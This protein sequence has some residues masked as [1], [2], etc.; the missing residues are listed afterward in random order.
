MSS[1]PSRR[2][3]AKP[4]NQRLAPY[5][6]VLP[7]MLIFGLF[8]V[9]P[10]INNFNISLYDS[11]NGR[12]FTFVGGAN[13]QE[14]FGSEAFC[15]AARA[16]VVFATCFVVLTTV[17]SV[18]LALMLNQ[19]IK[20]RAFFR[21]VFFLP[22]VLSPVVVGLIWG[23]IF[24]RGNGLLNTVL[25]RIGLGQPGWLVDGGLATI[26][27]I[28]VGLWMH[29]GFYILIILAGLQGID[30]TYYEAAR[31]D[32]ATN[33]QQLR[34]ITLP[35]LRP[36]TMVVVILSLIA[37]FQAFDYIWTLT[38]GGPIG[39]TTL[40]VQYIYENAFQ[41]PIRYGLAAAASVVLF[42]TVFALTLLNFLY[43]R[44]KEAT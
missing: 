15:S 42:V 5:L 7:N 4:W 33:W 18:A 27:V 9:Y 19:R 39:A 3:R 22:V 29:I 20:G 36:T 26:V 13:Y 11:R 43:G 34:K 41:S 12:D 25:A 44:R 17:L 6:F 31:M 38:G 2:A 16:T 32:G 23:W 8:V 37:G 24:D 40:M 10:A 28:F 35:L 1:T 30:P 14:L 21:T